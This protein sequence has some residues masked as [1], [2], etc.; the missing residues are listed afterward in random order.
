MPAVDG[1]IICYDASSKGSFQPVEALLSQ[2]R[3][4]LLPIYIPPN[5]SHSGGYRE[6]K[7]PLVVLA[8]KSDLT[9]EID[10]QAALEV[11]RK[12]DVGLVEVSLV[13]DGGKEKMKRSFD[14]L[15]RAVLRDR[16]MASSN[17]FAFFN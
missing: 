12:Y 10:P 7:L 5:S 2:S 17:H 6:M 3:I 13:K 16:R 14:W 8:C 1:V 15:L 11:L 9:Q 4:P